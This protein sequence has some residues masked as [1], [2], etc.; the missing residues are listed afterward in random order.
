MKVLMIDDSSSDRR[1]YRSLLSEM[2]GSGLQFWDATSAA[3]G[4]ELCRT[5]EPDCVL[6]DYRLPD[7]TGLECLTMIRGPDPAAVP[8][9][10]IVMLAGLIDE[11]I[12]VEA[13]RGGAQDYL[14]KDGITPEGLMSAIQR[15]TE[16][17][18]LIRALEQERDR[19]AASLAEKEVLLKEV[20]HRVKN[21]LQVVAS[22]LRLQA[23]SFSNPELEAALR[24][25]QN[26]VESM[27]LVH[28]QLYATEHLRE[29][30]LAQQIHM[31]A[32][33]LLRG[34]GD[35]T[36]ISVLA[37]VQ[38]VSLGINQAIPVSLILNELISN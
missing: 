3:Q 21:N 5:V 17:V 32:A 15:A 19:L 20:H 11:Q 14:V 33:N 8:G 13:M 6:L 27:A 12:V 1:L 29:V 34:Y 28:E 10:A 22:L 16:R 35:P 26:R 2:L 25:S 24:E 36:R 31:L 4:I 38:P 9:F 30:D 18:G 37:D 7:M 23:D